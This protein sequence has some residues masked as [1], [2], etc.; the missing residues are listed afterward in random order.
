ME[1]DAK[2]NATWNATYKIKSFE[3][4]PT[5]KA[6]IQTLCKVMQEAAWDH[7]LAFGLGYSQMLDR[8]LAWV[9]SRLKIRV[10]DFPRWGDNIRIRTWPAGVHRIFA[11]RDFQVLDEAGA[12]MAEAASAWLILDEKSRRP[13]RIEPLFHEMRIPAQESLFDFEENL[14]RLPSPQGYRMQPFFPVRFSDLDWH[15]HVNN[16]KYLEWILDSY[17]LEFH[18]HF[19]VA[20][21][22][23]NLLSETHY[24]DEISICTQKLEDD[25]PTYLNSILRK[26]DNQEICVACIDWRARI[27]ENKDE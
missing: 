12:F 3:V 16:S 20:A 10:F 7:A 5:K 9:L 6:T 19:Q 1:P 18:T 4:D 17:T 22:R 27:K 14:E 2:A 8:G 25:P 23:I 24:G 15:N 11:L 13:T 26:P 21:L